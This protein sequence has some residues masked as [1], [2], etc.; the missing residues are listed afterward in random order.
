MELSEMIVSQSL[1]GEAE[2]NP[3]LQFRSFVEW[4]FDKDGNF[5]ES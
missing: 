1:L 2:K 5:P 3:R 4:E